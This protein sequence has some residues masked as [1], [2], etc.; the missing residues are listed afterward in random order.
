MNR[1]E[2]IISS[3]RLGLNGSLIWKVQA[4]MYVAALVGFVAAATI[5]F[6]R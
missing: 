3:N 5:S 4:A 2:A 1:E 6:S